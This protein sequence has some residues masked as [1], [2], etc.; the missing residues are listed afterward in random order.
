VSRSKPAGDIIQNR[1]SLLDAV[2]FHQ[3]DLLDSKI[4]NEIIKEIE[5]NYIFHLGSFSSV[6]QSWRGPLASF[7]NNTNTFLNIVE[8]VRIPGQDTKILSVGSSGEYGIGKE[9]DLPLT[10]QKCS[11]GE[12]V[13]CRTSLC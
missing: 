1:D 3:C 12:S 7:L 8:A 13:C 6:A 4:I 2:A 11:T 10:G 9:S 5:P